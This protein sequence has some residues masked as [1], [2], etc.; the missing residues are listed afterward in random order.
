MDALG[1][2]IDLPTSAQWSQAASGLCNHV[3]SCSSPGLSLTRQ[4]PGMRFA[5][6]DAGIQTPG[7]NAADTGRRFEV[8]AAA[9]LREVEGRSNEVDAAEG[10]IRH[11]RRRFAPVPSRPSSALPDEISSSPISNRIATA[12]LRSTASLPLLRTLEQPNLASLCTAL[13]SAALDEALI[14]THAR[15]PGCEF[16]SLSASPMADEAVTKLA[17]TLSITDDPEEDVSCHHHLYRVAANKAVKAGQP[18][19]MGCGRDGESLYDKAAHVLQDCC[20]VRPNNA[21]F[22]VAERGAPYPKLRG[23]TKRGLYEG[24]VRGGSPHVT[25][26]VSGI[27]FRE[28]GA[29][30]S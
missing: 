23:W 21:I 1:A 7:K 14:I 2:K 28:L 17:A 15:Y 11:G 26:C 12:T 25:S 18:L 29:C 20:A 22:P 6:E 19:P 24:T 5:Q 4:V 16:L 27:S 13:S 8:S 9:P 10:T 30:A 3:E